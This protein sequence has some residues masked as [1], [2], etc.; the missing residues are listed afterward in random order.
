[1][2]AVLEVV[3]VGFLVGGLYVLA[4]AGLTLTYGVLRVVNFAHGQF[5]MLGMYLT[6]IFQQQLGLDPFVS[7]PITAALVT[8]LAW[9]VYAVGIKPTITAAHAVQSFVTLG[10]GLIATNVVLV[11]FSGDVRS[12]TSFLGETSTRVGGISMANTYLVSFAVA[13]LITVLLHVWVQRTD[14]GKA[15]RAT[16][17]NPDAARLMGIDVERVYLV[18][19]LVGTG[20]AGLAGVLFAT[21][22]P[23]YPTVG[24]GL[25]LTAFVVVVLGGLGSIPGAMLGG[26]LIGVV[27]S[28]S[29]YYLGAAS[30]QIVYFLV[31]VLVLVVRPAGLMGIKGSQLLGYR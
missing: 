15:I 24:L 26:L 17:Q 12:V 10:L 14:F 30:R 29:A 3:V 16:T 13:T 31:F 28:V 6:W 4:S 25:V 8:L 23:I 2:Q 5:V 20:L 19:F 9:V 21:M 1:M 22:Y 18:T 11:L 27:E 7:L